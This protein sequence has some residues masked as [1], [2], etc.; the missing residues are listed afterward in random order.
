[1]G[2]PRG[3][4]NTGISPVQRAAAVFAGIKGMDGTS[5][6]HPARLSL[7]SSAVNGGIANPA[8]AVLDVHATHG[9]EIDF[10]IYAFATSLGNQRVLDAA[11]ALAEQSGL[12]AKDLTLV[13]RASTYA[14][15]DPLAASPNQNDY[16]KTV[17]PFL[18]NIG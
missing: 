16:L 8:D 4:K 5:W 17:V 3:W 7:D 9:K 15:C 11:K 1:S 13:N 6:Y 10:P 18:R 12:P 14:H 2:T